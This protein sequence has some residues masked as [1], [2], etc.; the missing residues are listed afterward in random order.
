M[1]RPR[2][3]QGGGPE[4]CSY[5]STWLHFFTAAGTCKNA[6]I[7]LLIITVMNTKKKKAATIQ[8]SK[9]EIKVL[10]LRTKNNLNIGC[11]VYFKSLQV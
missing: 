1:I 11:Q 9:S 3:S 7:N 10:I 2:G 6:L 4:G 8:L 5:S